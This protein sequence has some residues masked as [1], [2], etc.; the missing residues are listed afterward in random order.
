MVFC[1]R[2]PRD[3]VKVRQ[4]A[5]GAYIKEGGSGSIG[6]GLRCNVTQLLPDMALADAH[7][8][9]AWPF[10]GSVRSCDAES[11]Q[12][13]QMQFFFWLNPFGC[14]RFAGNESFVAARLCSHWSNPIPE[15]LIYHRQT[16]GE[17]VCAG[18]TI[19]TA[20]PTHEKALSP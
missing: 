10:V 3:P 20:F 1:F 19:R 11:W 16:N 4:D 14:P 17:C 15:C 2:N 18:P 9:S 7:T 12:G 13:F 6:K 5:T 8:M